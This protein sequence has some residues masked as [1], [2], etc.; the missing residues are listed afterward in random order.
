[1]GKS[2][3]H[4]VF[5]IPHEHRFGPVTASLIMQKLSSLF[6]RIARHQPRHPNAKPMKQ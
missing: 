1:M 3:T 6:G 5:N 4:Q 2:P